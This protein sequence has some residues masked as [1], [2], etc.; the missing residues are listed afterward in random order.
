MGTPD[1][2]VSH[3]PGRTEQ[4][5]GRFHQATQNGAQ[6]KPDEVLANKQTY[7]LFVSGHFHLTVLSHD[8]PLVMKQWVRGL[9]CRWQMDERYP[10]D[11]EVT[12]EKVGKYKSFSGT[13]FTSPL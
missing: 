3:V 13:I 6:C 9:L 7:K 4:S 12:E 8:R 5:G 11:R 2:G 10:M 1:K